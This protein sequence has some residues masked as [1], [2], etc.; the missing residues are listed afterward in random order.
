MFI[1]LL[2]IVQ[3][4][5]DMDKTT[6]ATID[7]GSSRPAVRKLSLILALKNGFR[8]S[9]LPCPNGDDQNQMQKLKKSS[10]TAEAQSSSSAG[11]E[12]YI[13]VKLLYF[14]NYLRQ[15]THPV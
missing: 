3:R 6:L 7:V 9:N 10:R 8:R 14:L 1:I 11:L 2:K 5:D 12:L 4:G 15:T 13:Q